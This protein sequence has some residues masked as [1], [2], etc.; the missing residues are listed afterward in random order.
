M[1]DFA[2]EASEAFRYLGHVF[3]TREMEIFEV[4]AWNSETAF[5]DCLLCKGTYNYDK[6]TKVVI[7]CPG[8][9]PSD[10]ATDE[11]CAD[12]WC[13]EP[14]LRVVWVHPNPEDV[15]P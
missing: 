12:V 4:A 9:G 11:E 13:P 1:T 10:N 15:K 3:M 14:R 8:E 7:G 5:I 2:K 6:L